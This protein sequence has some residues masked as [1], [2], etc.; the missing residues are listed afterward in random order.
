MDRAP[1]VKLADPEE[2][3]AVLSEVRKLAGVKLVAAPPLTLMVP[4]EKLIA[5][6]C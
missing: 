3:R 6:C 5:T 4:A 1:L 2:P